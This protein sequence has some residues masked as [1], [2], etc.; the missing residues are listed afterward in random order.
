[1]LIGTV[2]R[3][4]A[5]KDQPNLARA[6]VKAV[7]RHPGARRQLRLIM[8]GAGQNKGEV[9]TILRDAG[10][11]DLVWFAGER[12]DVA[13]LLQGLDCFVRAAG[14]EGVSNTIL[15]AMSSGLPVVATRVG[16]N[17]E[18]VEDG[19][20]GRLV[21]AADPDALALEIALY[22]ENPTMAKRHGR[23]GGAGS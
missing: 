4:E 5:V 1:W 11:R 6:F 16:A 9:E 12:E 23:A 19:I 22:S 14:A 8:V 7:Q 3:M 15:E 17:A 21:E 10:V 20:T 18:L 2:G 13:T